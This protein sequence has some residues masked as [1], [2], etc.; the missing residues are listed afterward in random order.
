MLIGYSGDHLPNF[1]Y[2]ASGTAFLLGFQII[3]DENNNSK[4]KNKGW[5]FDSTAST[6]SSFRMTLLWGMR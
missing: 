4:G 2:L 6:L 5:S 1:V 3:R